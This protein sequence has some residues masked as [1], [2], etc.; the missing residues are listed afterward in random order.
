MVFAPDDPS[1]CNFFYSGGRC[2]SSELKTTLV[3]IYNEVYYQERR[4]PT[5]TSIGE[6]FADRFLERIHDECEE[7]E[8]KLAVDVFEV[9]RTL[10]MRYQ[11]SFS[12]FDAITLGAKTPARIQ[13]GF[14]YF[15]KEAFEGIVFFLR[16]EVVRV[17]Y[18]KI[19]ITMNRIGVCVFFAATVYMSSLMIDEWCVLKT[20]QLNIPI[21]NPIWCTDTFS[22]QM[23]Y[24]NVYSGLNLAVTDAI[25][26][27]NKNQEISKKSQSPN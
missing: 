26:R 5:T 12:W 6:Y 2:L 8:R 4:S 9:S 22:P 24:I 7:D 11:S 20:R 1:D 14:R 10:I 3:N 18:M 17:R 25:T 15:D 19:E 16:T 27:R 21:S 13:N 23:L